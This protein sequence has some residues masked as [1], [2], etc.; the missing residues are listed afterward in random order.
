LRLCACACVCVCASEKERHTD[1]EG[2]VCATSSPNPERSGVRLKG[3]VELAQADLATL[4]ALKVA[5]AKEP[6]ERAVVDPVPSGVLA[7]CSLGEV[8]AMCVSGRAGTSRSG[9]SIPQARA[10]GRRR[11]GP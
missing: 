3:S 9:L 4:E 8:F 1:S 2:W 7:D 6:Q 5:P 10:G 11:R